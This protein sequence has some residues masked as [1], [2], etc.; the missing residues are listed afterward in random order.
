V[1]T[2]SVLSLSHFKVILS[3]A[4]AHETELS[5][6]HNLA[7][8][9]A[10]PYRSKEKLNYQLSLKNSGSAAISTDKRIQ[11]PLSPHIRSH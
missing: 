7:N 2:K 5:T 1:Q 8:N 4:H 3:L 9:N 11:A 6:P 10:S